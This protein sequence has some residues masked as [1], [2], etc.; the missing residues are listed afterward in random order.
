MACLGAL[1]V[2]STQ[3][4]AAAAVPAPTLSDPPAGLRGYPMWDSYSD[5]APA[6]YEEHEYF[7][8]GTAVDAAGTSAGYRTRM[9]VS[10]PSDPARFNGVVLLDWVNVTAQFENAVDT[11]SARP[12]LLREGFAFVHLS[13]QAAGLCCIPLTPQGWDPVRYA[14]IVHPGD[15][16]SFDILSQVAQAFRTPPADPAPDPMGS[17]GVGSVRKVLATGQSQSALRLRDYVDNWLPAHPDA[18][19]LIDGFLIHGDVGAAKP[20]RQAL[21][22]KVLNLLSDL[23]ARNDGFDPAT[24][25]PNY[26]LWEVAGAGHSDYWIGHQSVA[27][28]GPRVLLGAPKQ[29]AEQLAATLWAAGNYGERV[30][31]ELAACVV[32]GNTMPMHYV[33][34]SAIHQLAD[35][36]DGGPAPVSGPRFTFSADGSQAKDGLGN[37]MG[38]I[39]LPPI[40]VPVA[41]Y[42]STLCELG[43]ITIPF[44]DLQLQQLYRSH[45]EYERRMAEATDRSVAEGWVLPEDAVDLMAR[46]CAARIR[47]PDATAAC[48]PY[49]PPAY[50]TVRGAQAATFGPAPADGGPM[51]PVTGRGTALVWPLVLVASA[52][53]LRHTAA[54]SR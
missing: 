49:T 8:S 51:L 40:E 20:F 2:V 6:G 17:L 45:A 28:H 3:V 37:P 52:L 7:V 48:A 35:W 23:E 22:V 14:S 26:K 13:L 9:I 38:G 21:P 5:L 25:D 4:T 50:F 19:G 36:V 27:G 47:F 44:T 12:A 16:F 34:A 42:A 1:L 11:I 43:G 32:A 24:A 31:P 41:Q 46:V 39:R 29:T 10:R 30:D 15:G 33:V 18:V 53:L 54:R